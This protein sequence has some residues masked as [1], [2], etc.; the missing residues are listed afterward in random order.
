MNAASERFMPKHKPTQFL[1][2]PFKMQRFIWN[3]IKMATE[4]F[5]FSQPH[6]KGIIVEN[7]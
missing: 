2:M 1:F 4:I 5:K 6:Y 3:A 7:N